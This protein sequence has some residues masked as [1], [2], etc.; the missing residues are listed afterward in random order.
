MSSQPAA[1]PEPPDLAALSAIVDAACHEGWDHQVVVAIAEADPSAE[2]RAVATAFRFL[3][4]RNQEHPDRFVLYEPQADGDWQ[5]HTVSDIPDTTVETWAAVAVLVEHPRA[6][7]RLHDL[8]FERRHGNVGKHATAAIGGYLQDWRNAAGGRGEVDAIRR[9]LALARMTKKE[10]L[11]A[12]AVDA[13]LEAIRATLT[14]PEPKAG[15]ALDLLEALIEANVDAPEIDDLLTHARTRYPHAMLQGHTIDL[16]RRR[17]TDN[18]TRKRLDRDEVQVWL[19]EAA[20]SDP[21]VRLA[22]LQTA[23]NIA[24]KRAVPDLEAQAIRELQQID[25][26]DIHL[27]RFS[28][29]ITVSRDLVAAEIESLLDTPTWFVAAIRI[30]FGEGP[31]SGDI[32]RNRATAAELAA[33]S[34]LLHAFPTMHLGQDRLP[35]Y[36]PPT[37]EAQADDRLTQHEVV[38]LNHMTNTLLVGA[39]I[40]AG[41]KFGPPTD[42]EIVA[43]IT[44][45]LIDEPTKKAIAR[46]IRRFYDDDAEAAVYTGLPLIERLVRNVLLELDEPIYRLQDNNKPGQY[47]GLGTLL[48]TLSK[49][50][51]D[52]SW[53]RYL[54]ALLTGP[55]GLN[56]RNKA[57]HGYVEQAGLADAVGVIVSLL[58]LSG[59]GVATPPPDD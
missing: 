52:P 56:L 10:D 51:F 49:R 31:P 22:H 50:G 11:V 25:P 21:L 28:A 48:H 58:Y 41:E 2:A 55:S 30:V 59:I 33:A 43:G 47:P 14:D 42:D 39:F 45:P 34:P 1:D 35:R 3:A 23:A 57:L 6:V 13:A 37:P 29:T 38:T 17:A 5:P 26:A 46:V 9:A 19:D 44:N 16:Q 27:Q 24:H 32:D 36:T 7:A 54:R 20:R 4:P 18:K 40:R 12:Q 15:I 8:L 53:H